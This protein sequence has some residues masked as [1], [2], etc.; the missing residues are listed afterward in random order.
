MMLPLT[1]FPPAAPFCYALSLMNLKQLFISTLVLSACVAL[2]AAAQEKSTVYLTSMLGQVSPTGD[3]G[4]AYQKSLSVTTGIEARIRRSDFYVIGSI[5][6]DNVGYSQQE[7]DFGTQFLIRDATTPILILS[8]NVGKSF[9]L[10]RNRKFFVAPYVG[11][12]YI[13]VSEPRVDIS[14]NNPPFT[15]TIERDY[16]SGAIGR[17]GGRLGFNTGKVWLPTI[18]IDGSYWRS[19]NTP[20][21]GQPA[22]AYTLMLGT[23]YGF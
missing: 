1:H 19:T 6:Y 7:R 22:Q 17:V 11:T 15:A 21:N 2:P 9:F 18:M 12:G 20:Y 23:R 3:F 10:D 4:N 5:E 16:S 8:V 14:F 13:N